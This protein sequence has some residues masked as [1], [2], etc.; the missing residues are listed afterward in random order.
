MECASQAQL[1]FKRNFLISHLIGPSQKNTQNFGGS[2]KIEVYILQ[3][4]AKH[5]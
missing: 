4:W 5:I 3:V 2:H 1:F